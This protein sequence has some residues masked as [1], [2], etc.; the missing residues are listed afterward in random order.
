MRVF[1]FFILFRSRH[2]YLLWYMTSPSPNGRP[3]FLQPAHSPPERE[4]L[5]LPREDRQ[6]GQFTETFA[7]LRHV[8]TPASQTHEI[9]KHFFVHELLCRIVWGFQRVVDGDE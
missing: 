4:F 3:H 5:I 6:F 9:A 8:G 2:I 7:L 1:L